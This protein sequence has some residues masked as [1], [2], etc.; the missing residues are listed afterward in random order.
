MPKSKAIFLTMIMA[1]LSS[2]A[3]ATNYNYN[4]YD[5]RGGYSYGNIRIQEEN[6]PKLIQQK[7]PD[8]AGSIMNGYEAGQRIRLRQQ[9]IEYYERLNSQN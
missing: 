6:E 1:I 4:A 9:K 8:Y 5:S 3:C 2:E 7:V